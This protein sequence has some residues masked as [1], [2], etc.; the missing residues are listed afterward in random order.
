LVRW[1]H[2][3]RGL[4]YPGAFVEVAEDTGLIAAIDLWVLNQAC[5]QLRRWQ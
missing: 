1:Q 3:T 2:P 5:Q 4:L